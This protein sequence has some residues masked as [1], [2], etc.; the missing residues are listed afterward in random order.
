MGLSRDGRY[1]CCLAL[2]E[3]VVNAQRPPGWRQDCDNLDFVPTT[4]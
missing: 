2:T 3:Q 1:E 4:F